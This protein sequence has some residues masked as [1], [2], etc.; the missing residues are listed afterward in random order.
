MKNYLSGRISNYYDQFK[1]TCGR[2]GPKMDKVQGY[3]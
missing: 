3:L 1:D 2:Y